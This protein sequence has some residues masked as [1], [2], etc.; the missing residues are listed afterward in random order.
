M[1]PNK[2]KIRSAHLPRGTDLFGFILF[3]FLPACMPDFILLCLLR[4]RH[5]QRARSA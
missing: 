1:L 3:L 2:K 4:D 5:G